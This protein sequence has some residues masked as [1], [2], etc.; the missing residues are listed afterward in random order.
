MYVPMHEH[1]YYTCIC[2]CVY[3]VYIWMY[4]FR[5]CV[6]KQT[7]ILFWS[8][9]HVHIEKEKKVRK[10]NFQSTQLYLCQ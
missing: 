2:V 6:Y 9:D 3:G 8:Y 5:H 10:K 1:V 7:C 4:I